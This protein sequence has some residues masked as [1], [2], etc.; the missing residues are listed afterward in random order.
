MKLYGT[1]TGALDD[2]E[3]D[4]E[5]GD[6]EDEIQKELSDIRKP[7]TKPLFTSIKLDTQC[8]KN[9]YLTLMYA[10]TDFA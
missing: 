4:T 5:G 9:Y 1:A 6:I 10:R 2:D 8:R 7:D 3:S